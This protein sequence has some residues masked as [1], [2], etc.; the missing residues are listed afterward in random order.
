MGFWHRRERHHTCSW[1]LGDLAPGASGTITITVTVDA[2]TPD[3]TTLLNT[4]TLDYADANGN[5]YP[6]LSDS[7]ETSVTAPVMTISKVADNSSADPSDTI[8]YTIVYENTGSGDA[9]DV[10][11][12]D[13]IPA[14]TT[15]VSASPSPDQQNGDVFTW[16][17][18]TVAGETSGTITIT[19]TVDV[20]TD[21]GTLLHNVVTLNYD[22]ANGNPQDEESDYADVT[23]T[24]P[25]MT[26]T[27]TADVTS[28]DPS[29]TIVYTLEYENARSQRHDRLHARIRE[30]RKR[31]RHG[32]RRHGHHPG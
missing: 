14:D 22:D 15:F 30:R 7:A 4:A 28:A 29:D 12:E 26:F 13:T 16:N 5:F 17:V 32:C 21:D 19:V 3:G 10:V 23:V 31:H 9:T 24:A 27:K 18:G 25:V 20:G 6:R 11:V 2:Y 1:D 8:V